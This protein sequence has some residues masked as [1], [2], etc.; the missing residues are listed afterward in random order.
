MKAQQFG[1]PKVEFTWFL[2]EDDFTK[3]H[4]MTTLESEKGKK[5]LVD[6]ILLCIDQGYEMR[7]GTDGE[8]LILEANYGDDEYTDAGYQ[9][10]D[11]DHCIK[12]NG[13]NEST[14]DADDGVYIPSEEE[15]DDFW[16]EK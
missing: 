7:I 15:L 12:E 13:N 10:V 6:A 14:G 1:Q 3:K 4:Y 2:R 11:E 5:Q 9:Y 8:C 16:K